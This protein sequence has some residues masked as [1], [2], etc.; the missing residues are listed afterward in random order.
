[1]FAS[2]VATRAGGNETGAKTS[3]KGNFR[4]CFQKNGEANV[5]LKD[6]DRVMSKICW[7][8]NSSSEI[9]LNV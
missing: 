7:D 9:F 3:Q 6:T 4:W 1:M 8:I 5:L 2:A